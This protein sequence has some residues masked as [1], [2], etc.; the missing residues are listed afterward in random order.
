MTRIYHRI[1]DH[2]HSIVA[3]NPKVQQ[4]SAHACAQ[5]WISPGLQHCRLHGSQSNRV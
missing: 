4:V 3:R 1:Q 2:H 5:L